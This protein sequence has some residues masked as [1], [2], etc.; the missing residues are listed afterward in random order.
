MTSLI[1]Q[2]SDIGVGWIVIL[3]NYS[4]Y[5]TQECQGQLSYH[6]DADQDAYPNTIAFHYD[7]GHWT[8]KE[9]AAQK[10]TVEY[11]EEAGTWKGD[12]IDPEGRHE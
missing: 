12:A 11:K 5:I 3:S 2:G 10:T 4:S 7:S 1:G 8:I 6:F 9:H